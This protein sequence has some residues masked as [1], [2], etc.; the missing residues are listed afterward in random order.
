MRY[1]FLFILVLCSSL[2]SEAQ[3]VYGFRFPLDIPPDISGNFG[4]LRSSHYH[5]GLDFRTQQTTGLPI[6]ACADG[7]IRRLRIGYTGYGKVIYIDHPNGLTTVYAHLENFFGLTDSLCKIIQYASGD[8]MFDTIPEPGKF[9]VRKGEIIGFSGN[10]GS[11]RG[12]HLHFE[13]RHSESQE[14]LNPLACGFNVADRQAPVFTGFKIYRE[15]K[16]SLVNGHPSDKDFKVENREGNYRIRKNHVIRAGGRVSLAVEVSDRFD[17]SAF[18]NGIYS[19]EAYVNDSLTFRIKFDKF[20]FE[21]SKRINVHCDYQDRIR[22]DRDFEKLSILP[23][24]NTQVYD[25]KPGNGILQCKPG[26]NYRVK[27]K[28]CDYAGNCSYL[29]VNLI[30]ESVGNTIPELVTDSSKIIH[31]TKPYVY[32]NNGVRLKLP[33]DGVFSDTPLDVIKTKSGI[34]PEYEVGNRFTPLKK[35]GEIC[36]EQT[37]NSNRASSCFI[38]NEGS[39]L[40]ALTDGKYKCSSFNSFGYA[41][42]RV[43]TISPSIRTVNLG[44]DKNLYNERSIKVQLTDNQSGVAGWKAWIDD[45]MYLMEYEQKDNLLFARVPVMDNGWHVL[46]VNVWDKA[47]NTNSLNQRFYYEVPVKEP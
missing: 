42:L 8:Y 4:Q 36:I 2:Y 33:I 27:V 43:D 15:N 46:R 12:P 21:E 38:V 13:V 14:A 37:L 29:N 44:I 9:K 24:D 30:G 25:L 32:D 10:T 39:W 17:A 40:P 23:N 20:S 19:L 16:E 47:M 11:S 3:S 1:L 22:L 6:Y 18:R 31:F 45:E 28:A 26:E 7:F 41:A 34:F 5:A 35:S